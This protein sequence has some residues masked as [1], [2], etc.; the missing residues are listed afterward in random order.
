[1]ADPTGEHL[2]LDRLEAVDRLCG[3]ARDRAEKGD[4]SQA[5]ATYLEAWE[6]LP[7][8]KEGW[9]AA[10]RILSAVGDLMHGGGDLSSAL[11]VVLGGKAVKPS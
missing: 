8:P 10:T 9:E 1:M 11:E 3:E 7:E 6:L 4:R 2:E 5:L